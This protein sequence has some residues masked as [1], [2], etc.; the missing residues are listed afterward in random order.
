M[1]KYL[2]ALAVFFSSVFAF[3]KEDWDCYFGLGF[4]TTFSQT[5]F[6]VSDD[7]G[8]YA[9]NMSGSSLDFLS[10]DLRLLEKNLPVAFMGQFS[11]G[12]YPYSHFE[13]CGKDLDSEFS[14]SALSKMSALLGL[15]YNF[16]IDEK[17]NIIVSGV[18]G[19]QA[20][21]FEGDFKSGN[22]ES[23]EFKSNEFA[24]GADVFA[25]YSLSRRWGI[26]VAL[27]ATVCPGGT[28]KI[29]S[30][31]GKSSAQNLKSQEKNTRPGSIFI[32]PR[33]GASIHF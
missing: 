6:S 21:D 24:L 3:A 13:I 15:G 27:T 33:L 4:G 31:E 28:C 14:D 10:F 11:I 2:V 7:S 8:S 9:A 29:N 5:R 22:D 32:S 26:F 20:L 19:L 30:D 18:L 25:N 12:L 23:L 16:I 1:K 17:F